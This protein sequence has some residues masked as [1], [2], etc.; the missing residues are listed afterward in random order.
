MHIVNGNNIAGRRIKRILFHGGFDNL[1]SRPDVVIIINGETHVTQ[2]VKK[3]DGN[4]VVE[5]TDGI[6]H[7]NDET[8]LEMTRW[9][10]KPAHISGY[11]WE[12]SLDIP[13][14][15]GTDSLTLTFVMIDTADFDLDISHLG[16]N[17]V[18]QKNPLAPPPED[19]QIVLGAEGELQ[20]WGQVADLV[21][22][23][24]LE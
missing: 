1:T 4:T 21:T 6:V 9:D 7:I 17:P 22:A 24:Y 8:Q 10:M 20:V 14:D 2:I 16:N 11:T 12:L 19:G 5:P 15:P 13:L 3:I 18:I 23:V